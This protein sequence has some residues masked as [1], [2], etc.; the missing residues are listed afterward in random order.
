MYLNPA[1]TGIT[2]KGSLFLW[3]RSQWFQFEGAPNTQMLSFA[4]PTRHMAFG[5]N[6]YYDTDGPLTRIK[7][8]FNFSYLVDLGLE[9]SMS[10]GLNIGANHFMYDASKITT[11]DPEAFMNNN[12]NATSVAAGV[13]VT[14]FTYK[15]YVGISSPN[16]A[17]IKVISSDFNHSMYFLPHVNLIGGMNFEVFYN[18]MMLP[19]FV[20]RYAP[21]QPLNFDTSIL[22]TFSDTF[23]VGFSYRFKAA[24]VLLLSTKITD[25]FMIGYSFDLDANKIRMFN[26]GSHELFLR[27]EFPT[28]SGKVRFQSPRL[29]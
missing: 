11:R 1:N 6:V 8:T 13:G 4:Y 25:K 23:T 14:F 7:G 17:P 15:W 10:L 9:T 22:F 18:V 2:G 12:Q 26:V 19:S 21:D 16:I 28:R 3:H 24:Y 27:Y 29:F 5:T 20:L